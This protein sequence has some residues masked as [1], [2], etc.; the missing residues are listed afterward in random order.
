[1]KA[2]VGRPFDSM[3]FSAAEA[4]ERLRKRLRFGNRQNWLY[5]WKHDSREAP[6]RSLHL[7]FDAR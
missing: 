3:S 2:W 4:S 5:A 7:M 1:M 6:K